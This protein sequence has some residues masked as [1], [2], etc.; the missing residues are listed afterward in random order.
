MTHPQADVIDAFWARRLGCLPEDLRSPGVRVVCSRDVDPGRMAVLELDRATI[1]RASSEHEEPITLWARNR[2]EDSPRSAEAVARALGDQEWSVGPSENVLYLDPAEFRPF[3]QPGVRPLCLEDSRDLTAMHRGCTLQ[4]QQ[5]GEVNID[6]PAIFGAYADG[7]LVAAASLIDQGDG[8]AD[9][10]VMVHRDYR[11][12]GFGRAAVSALSRWGLDNRRIVQ[13]SRL[14]SNTGYARI[15]D[16]L[17]FR[18]F[19]RYQNLFL[20]IPPF[21]W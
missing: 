5:A 18:E 13:Y 20:T 9:V 16:S 14:C 19:G 1:V 15:A 12:R 11:R 2:S 10:G 7:R 3:D 17:G 6:H 4:E 8:I 21:G